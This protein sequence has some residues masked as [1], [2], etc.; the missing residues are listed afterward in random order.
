MQLRWE[1]A[2]PSGAGAL[3]DESIFER[4]PGRGEY[5]GL[6]FLHVR[7]KR[8]INEVKGQSQLPFRFTI[9]AYRGCSHACTYCFARPTHTY[10]DL[11]ADH[12]FDTKIVVKVNAVERLRAELAPK[13]WASHH[14]AMGTNTDPYQRC[15]GKY[16]LTQGI[17]ETLSAARNPFSILTKSSLVLR[18]LDLLAEA[19]TRTDVRVNLSIGTLDEAVWRATE[20]GTPHPRQRVAA[21]AKLNAAGVPCGVLVAPVLPGISDAA[22]QLRG[23]R[24]G[25]RRRGGGDG[26]DGHAAPAARREGGLPRPLGA[27]PPAPRRRVHP[28]LPAR[29]VRAQGRAPARGADR[30]PRSVRGGRS[31]R[32][33]PHGERTRRYR[34]PR[35][36][37]ASAA[38]RP[39]APPVTPGIVTGADAISRCWW[40]GTDPLYL[41]YHDD[42]WGVPLHD[43]RALF[44]LLM[45]EGFQAGLA[46]ITILRK[47]PAFRA[48]FAGFDIA[49]VAAFG[50]A[51]V[52]RLL[53][54]AGIVRHRGKIEATIGNA[55]AVTELHA[56]GRRLS[57]VVWSHAPPTR[58]RRPRRTDD[59]PASTAQ[60]VALSRELRRLGLRFVGPTSVYAFMQSAGVV[61]DHLAGCFRAAA[62]A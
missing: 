45:L 1:L 26:L 12:D 47:R 42:E 22:D 43:E 31:A 52:E 21:V 30:A 56:Q 57:D 18:D 33:V 51:D 10:L 48:A 36:N 53:G 49:S 29:V 7:T 32:A 59:V 14:I 11:D 34:A 2:E 20:P 23:G 16:R 62:T 19:A 61:D 58:R 44:E 37:R 8:I 28:P 6:E 41:A 39:V 13:R 4:E 50:T 5:R 25:M 60:S 27:D 17:V 35:G 40:A 9:N 46:W 3:F 54:D 15:E 38:A 24:R 55:R